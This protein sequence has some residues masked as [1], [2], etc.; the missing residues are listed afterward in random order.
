EMQSSNGGFVWFKGGPDDRYITQH[1]A[2]GIGQLR[3]L[4]AWP[5]AQKTALQQIAAKAVSYLDA[6]LGEDY[7]LLI[8]TKADLGKDHL[9]DIAI[10]YLYMRSFFTDLPLAPRWK[11]AVE[12]YNNQ[13]K[14][15]WPSKSKYAQGMI[16][17]T[18][19]R[20]K[21]APVAKAI[22]K[23]LTEN[24]LSSPEF[25]MYWKDFNNGG[26]Y[27]WQAPIESHALLIAAYTEIEAN[28]ERIND[29]KT[30]L[31][32]QKQTQSWATTRATA[33]ACYAL[34]LQGQNWLTEDDKV[35]IT[36]GRITVAPPTDGTE[37]GT[38]YFKQRLSATDMVPNMGRITVSTGKGKAK[39]SP[40]WGAVYWQY[41]DDLD[42][43]T[44]AASPLLLSKQLFVKTNGSRG[45]ELTPLG[46]NARL[47]VGDKITV[48]MELR[49]DRNL[50]YV[51]L[52]DMRASCFEPT[53]V[54][55]QYKYQ[56][57]LGYY[58]ATRDASTNFFIGYLPRGTHV[59]EYTLVATH[60]GVFSNGI[61]SI[62]C[63]Y[64][65]EF[66]AHSQG[67]RVTVE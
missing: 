43:I 6:R 13:A 9:G 50:E 8:G 36:L 12:F 33:E 65:P 59:F 4:N 51:H 47:K 17:L 28:A 61:G 30:W 18:L 42:K 56:N 5:A 35:R 16:A 52:K 20:A 14:K 21:N 31:L 54:L 23:S 57:G 67:L 40:Q 55:S 63:M 46:P 29:L 27:W 39:S 53:N 34:L 44:Q 2:T 62:Q 22:L 25:G 45:P 64:A 66:G 32:K 38:G 10:Q 3:H 7:N 60:R 41:F 19:Q 48:R 37:A 15:Y 49:S 1:I 58:E 24:S 26:Y 11:V